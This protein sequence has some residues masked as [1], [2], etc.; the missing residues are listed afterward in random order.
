ML[1][2]TRMKL[3][4]SPAKALRLHAMLNNMS[5]LAPVITIVST[6][7]SLKIQG[8]DCC[9]VC[10][11][12]CWF[13]PS[14]FDEYVSGAK[15]CKH[16]STK[17][18]ATILKMVS[19][20]QT[21]TLELSDDSLVINFFGGDVSCDKEFQLPLMATD[22]EPIDISPLMEEETTA[23]LCMTSK[24]F[25]DLVSQFELFD[26]VLTFDLT[27][28]TVKM[29]ASGEAGSMSAALDIDEGHLLEYEIVE[30][31]NLKQSFSHRFVK[32]MAS[33]SS[34]SP[35]CDLLFFEGRP[36]FVIYKMGDE[37]VEEKVI[38]AKLIVML[39]PRVD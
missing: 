4:I 20:D 33:F 18:L 29:S 15:D 24:K 25:S 22:Y 30:E 32:S 6:A 35:E 2:E 10:L 17:I 36:M 12:D 13:C 26:E 39:A 16:V 27:E 28:N 1:F 8:M 11:F 38:R 21:V 7:Q 9:Q 37:G 23:E 34:L 5:V 3:S 19:K 14:W 31:A